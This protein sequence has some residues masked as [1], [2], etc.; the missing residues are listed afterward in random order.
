MDLETGL[1]SQNPLIEEGDISLEVF[2]CSICLSNCNISEAISAQSCG[3][4]KFCQVCTDTYLCSHIVDGELIFKCPECVSV[5]GEEEVKR[6]VSPDMFVRYLRFKQIKENP[7]YRECPKCFNSFITDN[8]KQ[9]EI[10]CTECGVSYCSLHSLAHVGIT[11]KEY[12]RKQQTEQK[13]STNLINR[14]SRPCPT[15]ACDTEKAG[16]CNH[17]SCRQCGEVSIPQSLQS[18]YSLHV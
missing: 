2:Y 12:L 17:M 9:S 10:M 18:S 16:G 14:V 4:H 11:C 7:K 15:C 3:K 13:S 5:F 8:E 1:Q 6:I